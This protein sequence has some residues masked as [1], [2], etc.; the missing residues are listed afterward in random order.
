MASSVHLEDILEFLENLPPQISNALKKISDIDDDI[1]KTNKIIDREISSYFNSTLPDTCQAE[2]LQAQCRYIQ[3]VSLKLDKS[4]KIN[5]T[6]EK[7]DAKVSEVK[8]FK[9]TISNY[10]SK[11]GA[12]II[13]RKSYLDSNKKGTCSN[14]INRVMML[15]DVTMDDF[16]EY[17]KENKQSDSSV[18]VTP[19]TPRIYNNGPDRLPVRTSLQLIP[20]IRESST[21]FAMPVKSLKVVNPIHRPV[22]I[23]P[24]VYPL[25]KN[26]E[27]KQS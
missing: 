20:K 9:N 10:M 21:N 5:G 8:K 14:I 26:N 17:N 11:L 2:E 19:T 23:N 15:E 24:E 27:T 1:S 18:V 22:K 13:R 12:E 3:N 4:L 16:I 6:I 25:S 7:S